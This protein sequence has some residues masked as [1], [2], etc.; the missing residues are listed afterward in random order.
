MRRWSPELADSIEVKD[1]DLLIDAAFVTV[2]QLKQLSPELCAE[3]GLSHGAV[4]LFRTAL[5]Q[6]QGCEPSRSS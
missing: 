6:P 3:L 5:S 4:D 1:L 2:P